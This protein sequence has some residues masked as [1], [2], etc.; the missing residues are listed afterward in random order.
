MKG[1]FGS[2]H[3][4]QTATQQKWNLVA[5]L[6]NDIVGGN[7]VSSQTNLRGNYLWGDL[8]YPLFKTIF[9]C[10]CSVLL[11]LVSVNFK[12]LFHWSAGSGLENDSPQRELA[13][14]VK[15]VGE[16]YV[17]ELTVDL[18]YRQDRFL[19]GGDQV[20]VSCE[21]LCCDTT[22]IAR[23]HLLQQDSPQ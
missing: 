19:R 10:E 8:F 18:I 3:M 14:Y 17:D 13:R 12:Q 9:T 1:L 21:M 6:N 7:T 20:W 4:A 22:G 11:V 5:Q 16:R 2:T 15:E 23:I